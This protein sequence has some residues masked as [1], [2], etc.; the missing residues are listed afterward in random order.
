[1]IISNCDLEILD[2][3]YLPNLKSILLSSCDILKLE[4]NPQNLPALSSLYLSQNLLQELHLEG[5]SELYSLTCEKNRLKKITLHQVPKIRR[6]FLAQ[7]QLTSIDFL[8]E[9]TEIISLYIS[10]NDIDDMDRLS[11]FSQLESL[12]IAENPILSLDFIRHLPLLKNLILGNKN[13]ANPTKM[14][15]PNELL[16]NTQYDN[17][18]EKVKKYLGM[19]E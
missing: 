17:S 2:L 1:L 15:I 19:N 11:E 9:C 5:F 14:K 18:L 8:R 12:D 10:Y 16:G 3:Q 7:N 6:V 13:W 4:L